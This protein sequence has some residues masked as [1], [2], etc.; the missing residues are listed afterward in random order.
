[1]AMLPYS[2]YY[3]YISIVSFTIYVNICAGE[4]CHLVFVSAESAIVVSF[5]WC[6]MSEMQKSMQWCKV[7]T[8]C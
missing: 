7:G 5:R 6:H 1:M 2:I 8:C 4:C 3:T